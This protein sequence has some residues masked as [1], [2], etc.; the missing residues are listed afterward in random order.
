MEGGD[1]RKVHAPLSSQTCL[2][3]KKMS[4]QPEHTMFLLSSWKLL[5]PA[6][7]YPK[8]IQNPE[9]GQKCELVFVLP[10]STEELIKT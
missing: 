7:I 10:F 8:L 2:K 5:H 6:P 3:K 1:L 9:R 4:I